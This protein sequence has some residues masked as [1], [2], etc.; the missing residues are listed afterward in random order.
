MKK[1]VLFAI[2]SLAGGGAEKI[3][4]TIVKNI[5]KTKFDITVLTVV[6]T[7]VYVE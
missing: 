2:E 3:L 1:K 5:D 6:K 7:G 4:A